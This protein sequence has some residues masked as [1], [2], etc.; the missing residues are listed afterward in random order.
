[1]QSSKANIATTSSQQHDQ[2]S[3]AMD[4]TS[5]DKNDVIEVLDKKINPKPSY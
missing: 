1:V 4:I 5:D 2:F 3:E